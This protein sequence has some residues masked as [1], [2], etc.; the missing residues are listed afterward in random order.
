[1]THTYRFLRLLPVLL[2][3]GAL[4][5]CGGGSGDKTT[6]NSSSGSAGADTGSVNVLGIWGSSELDSFNAMVAGWNGKVNFTGSR[7]ITSLLTTRVEGNNPPDVALPAEI[8]LFQ[9]FAKEGKL[10]PLSKCPGLEKELKDNYPQSFLDL[11]TVNGTLYGF[12]MKADSKATIW[13]NPKFFQSKGYKPLTADSKFDD[14]IALADQIKKDG[15]PPFSMGIEAA[16]GSGYPGSDVIQQILLNDSGEKTYDAIVDGSKPFNDPAMADAWDKYGKLAL[17]QGNT[18]QGG[19]AGIN[20]TNFQDATYAPFQNPP[21]AAMVLLGGF[22]AGFIKT[23]FPNL[24]AGE[25][26]DF[27]PWPGGGVTGGAN[28]AY[29]FNANPGTCSFLSYLA[30]AD[31][32]SVW[33]KRGSFTSVNKKVPLDSYPDP[34]SKKLAQQLTTAK[35]FRFDLD[36]AI[37]GAVQTAEFKGIIQY[38]QQPNTLQQILQ[39]IQATRKP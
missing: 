4:T 25:D 38:L 34:V 37:G 18:A 16:G 20:A 21:R 13:Y 35:T 27:M 5:A 23:Q 28:I 33:V 2:L 8:G 14:L 10:T 26:Y 29:A 17:T 36:D 7:E 11:G 30:G 39:S 12:F 22:G 31:A 6:G 15:T 9:R 19:A 1:V 32:Q 3:A 24:K